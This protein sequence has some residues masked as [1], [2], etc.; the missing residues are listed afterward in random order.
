MAARSPATPYLGIGLG[1]TARHLTR[2][3]ANQK[4]ASVGLAPHLH[5]KLHRRQPTM[6]AISRE[7]G[8]AA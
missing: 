8:G 1:H 6:G 4:W 2:R 7:N 5:G 3:M